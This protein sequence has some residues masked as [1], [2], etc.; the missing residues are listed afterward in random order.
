MHACGMS[1]N[2]DPP[3]VPAR[4]YLARDFAQAGRT[5]A[6]LAHTRTGRLTRIRRGA[7]AAPSTLADLREDARYVTKVVSV[8]ETRRD[9]VAAGPSAAALMGLPVFGPWP[10]D[11]Y[12]LAPGPYSRRRNGVIEFARR[13]DE[14]TVPSGEYLVTSPVHTVLDACRVL[15]PWSALAVVDAAIRTDPFER[16]SPTTTLGALRDL[17]DSRLPYRGHAHVQRVLD[18]ARDGADSSLESV[19]RVVIEELGFPD[20]ILQFPLRLPV[21]ARSA[22]LD[23]AWPAYRIDGEADGWGKYGLPVEGGAASPIE[24]LKLEKRRDNAVRESGW[25]PV[26]WERADALDRT[27]LRRRL[28]GAGLPLVARPH[29]LF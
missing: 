11:V 3:P 6:L 29:R 8:L 4:L 10:A 14:V 20:P 23:F 18:F 27:R 17:H 15:P 7:Y 2:S 16:R 25:T 12:L 26:H 13:G 22:R 28:L 24:R 5:S 19:S 9:A 1:A 21:P